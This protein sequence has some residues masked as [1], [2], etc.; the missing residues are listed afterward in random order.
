[1]V[2]NEKAGGF[3]APAIKEAFVAKPQQPENI[4]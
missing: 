4:I 2:S 3:H 1:M